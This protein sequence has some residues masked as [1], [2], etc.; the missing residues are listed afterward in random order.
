[1]M[2]FKYVSSHAK[3]LHCVTVDLAHLMAY[4]AHEVHQDWRI[5]TR[6]VVGGLQS[7]H[8]R[9]QPWEDEK[10]CGCFFE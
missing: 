3:F 4:M 9:C 5:G 6:L 8:M 1:M 7:S 10:F 2:R